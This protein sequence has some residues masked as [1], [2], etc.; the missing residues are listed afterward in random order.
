MNKR[1]KDLTLEEQRIWRRE[2]ARTWRRNNRE[3]TRQYE[4]KRYAKRRDKNKDAVMMRAKDKLSYQVKNGLLTRGLCEACGEPATEG[5][6]WDYN[7][8]L[9]VIWLCHKCHH[10]FHTIER[11]TKRLREVAEIEDLM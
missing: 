8:P 7:R 10:V 2:Y 9:N 3:A 5:H 11:R 1:F 6:H 4:M